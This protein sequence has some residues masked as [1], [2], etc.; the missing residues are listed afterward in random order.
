M[1]GAQKQTTDLSTRFQLVF[2]GQNRARDETQCLEQK[3]KYLAT[4]PYHSWKK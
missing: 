1:K 4:E 2:L 3:D